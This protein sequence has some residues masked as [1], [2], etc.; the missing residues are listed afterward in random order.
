MNADLQL[1]ASQFGFGSGVFFLGYCLFEVPS[2]IILARVGARRWIARIMITWGLLAAALALTRGP[3]SFAVLR[4]FLGVAEA[5]FFPGV[6]FYLSSWYPARLR[7]RALAGFLLAIPPLG[8]H[9]RP[10]G[11]CPVEAQW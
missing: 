4:F 3:V 2:N 9:W 10:V 1:S 7:A 11:G 6:V 5:G 8:H